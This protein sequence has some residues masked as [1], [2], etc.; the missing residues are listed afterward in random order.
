MKTP[1]MK[2]HFRT[3]LVASLLLFAASSVVA[4]PRLSP[5][6]GVSQNVGVSDV[7]IVYS[8]PAVRERVIFG[9]LVPY[10]QIW[11]TGANEA[12]LFEISHDAEIE[13]EP[14]PAGRY[15]LFTVPGEDQWEIVFNSEAEQWGAYQADRSKD[16]LTV[17]VE[18]VT[19]PYAERM[20]FFFPEVDDTSATVHL[21]WA[22]LAVPFTIDFGTGPL[23]AAAE[24]AASEGDAGAITRWAR[25]MLQNDLETQKAEQWLAGIAGAEDASYWPVAVYARLQAHN[26]NADA[27][28]DTAE[29]AM[30]LA[31]G[32]NPQAQADAEQL[33]VEM[34]EWK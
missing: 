34:G 5:L 9:E 33:E 12:T 14:L 7:E 32:A 2:T 13:G 30:D 1:S 24:Q 25:Y 6:A 19:A 23:V 3:T 22:E 11:R 28:K 17:K 21:H 15:A 26:G 8:R 29:R 10:D 20:T 16:V 4:Q 18:P 31:Q 27:A